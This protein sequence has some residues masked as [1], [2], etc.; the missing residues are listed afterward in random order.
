MADNAKKV[1]RLAY[2]AYLADTGK[3][4]DTTDEEAAKEAEIYSDKVNYEP[5]SYIVGSNKLFPG[6]E[7][8]IGEAEVGKEFTVEL[9]AEEAAGA[10]N[11]RLLETHSAKEFYREE[12]N[13]MPGMTVSLGNRQG[14]ILSVGAGRVKVDFNNPLAGHDL[15]YVMTV[16]EEITDNAEKAKAIVETEFT[17]SE[18]FSFDF[19]EGKVVVTIPDLAKFDQNWAVA[20]FRIVSELREAFGVDTVE[21]IEVWTAPRKDAKADE[22]EKTE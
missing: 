20:R 16:T 2:K 18:G 1:I 11:P 5:M 7:K 6:L 22:S 9:P 14:T 4:Y 17:S 15:K 13:P 19:P 10:R 12:I 21:F 3:L 8:A